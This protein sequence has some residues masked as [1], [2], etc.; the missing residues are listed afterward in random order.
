MLLAFLQEKAVRQL[1]KNPR[2]VAGVGLAAAGA[3]VAEVREHA[4]R[5]GDDVVRFA[6]F[7]IDHEADAA[8]VVLILGII[9]ALF[10]RKPVHVAPFF[11][12]ATPLRPKPTESFP[13]AWT[14]PFISL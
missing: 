14:S 4:N 6:S 3:P 2:A 10:G 9:Q 12:R 13:Y 7:Q 5:L 11:L 1:Q 8:G